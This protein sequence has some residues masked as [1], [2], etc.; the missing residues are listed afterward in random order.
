MVED[1]FLFLPSFL[2]RN[3]IAPEQAEPNKENIPS[4]EA[5]IW[6]YVGDEVG[7]SG[8]IS[9][10]SSGHEEPAP[11]PRKHSPTLV[12][13][14]NKQDAR[15][16]SPSLPRR[17]AAFDGPQVGWFGSRTLELRSLRPS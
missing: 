4:R 16:V 8:S 13:L 1:G 11:Q 12:P 9:N 17:R 2:S 3:R 6:D 15:A 5:R 10:S 14:S 7:D